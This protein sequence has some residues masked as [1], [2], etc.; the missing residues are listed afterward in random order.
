MHFITGTR[1]VRSLAIVALLLGAAACS[2]SPPPPGAVIAS[3]PTPQ[4]STP[5]PSPTATPVDQQI[6]TA[7]R[8]YYAELTR[9]AQTNDT[10]KLKTMLAKS[11]PCYRAVRV[12][13]GNRRRGETTPDATFELI[14]VRVHD[15]VASSASAETRTQDSFYKVFDRSGAAIDRIGATRTHLDLALIKNA[16]GQ[17]SVTNTFDMENS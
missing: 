7:V 4:T 3:T 2:G 14:S 1:A 16:A 8:A 11:C 5:A 15:V 17:W 12:I 10:S 9:A 13:D 6:E